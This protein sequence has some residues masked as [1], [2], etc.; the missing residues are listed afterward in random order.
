M[1]K[2]ILLILLF[3]SVSCGTVKYIPVENKE[4]V[5]VRDS[6]VLKDSV[7]LSYINKERVIDIVPIYDTLKLETTYAR[8][9]SYVDTSLHKIK[10]EICQKDTIPVKNKITIQERTVYQD[11]VVEKQVPVEVQ[12]EKRFIPKWVWWSLGLNILIVVIF[13]WKASI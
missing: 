8:S 12:I 5:N 6:V 1:K 9:I 13:I 4:T 7:I 3:V 11:R 10:G 2:L